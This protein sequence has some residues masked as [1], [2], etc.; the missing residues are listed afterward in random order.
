VPD[1][2]GIVAVARAVGARVYVDAVHATPHR[3]VDLTALGADVVACSAYKWFGPH[4]G[5]LCARPELLEELRPDK[6]RP[7]PDTVPERFERGTLPFESLAG[8]AAA[9]DFMVEE[10]DRDALRAH[11]DG[12]LS[13][14]LGGLRAIP[15][16]TVHG[17][18]PDRT[19]TVMFTVEGR[20]SDE[21][22]AEL[23]AEHEVAVWGG[24]YY[25]LELSRHLG[26][27]PH[28]AVR[29]GAVAYT[30]AEDVQRL[31]DGVA[32]IAERAGAGAAA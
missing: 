23:A 19:P 13:R 11:E 22:A 1:L 8:V 25:A 26:L 17:D 30:S 20:T 32:A 24:N 7:S 14:M 16:V 29:A 21:V 5:V 27:E 28:G 3:A 9:A 10:L 4:V 6:L 2:A 15:G 12:L 31:L 18:P